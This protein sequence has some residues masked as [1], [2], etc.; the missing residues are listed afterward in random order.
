[1]ET[2]YPVLWKQIVSHFGL[3][4][5]APFLMLGPKTVSSAFALPA[6]DQLKAILFVVNLTKFAQK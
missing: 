5:V 4:V 3:L 1:V 6:A 2:K